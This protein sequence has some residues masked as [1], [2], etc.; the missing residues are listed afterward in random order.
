M[1]PPLS[2]EPIKKGNII[3]S[4]LEMFFLVKNLN[5]IAGDLVKVNDSMWKLYL[6]LRKLVCI[7]MLDRLNEKIIVDFE[8][9]ASKYLKLHK[10]LF[11]SPFK[12]KHHVILHY[13]MIMRLFGPLKSLSCE[14]FEDKH[15]DIKQTST[16]MTSRM[17][18]FYSLAMKHQ[19][20][21]C[22]RLILNK[23]LINQITLDPILNK[24]DF[25]NEQN[26]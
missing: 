25:N 9:L 6:I 12:F 17:N 7:T 13:P 2:M 19:L 1:P 18:P 16:V 23:K 26:F 24:M 22:H 3:L 21:F 20:Q 10:S 14:R 15:K 4:S 11:S 8:K 5:L